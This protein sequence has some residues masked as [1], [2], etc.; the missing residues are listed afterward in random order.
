MNTNNT[1]F[2]VHYAYGNVTEGCL[3]EARYCY[4]TAFLLLDT[5]ISTLLLDTSISATSA[6][7]EHYQPVINLLD[8][9]LQ[10]VPDF[11]DAYCLREEVWRN[12]L[13]I[14]KDTENRNDVYNRYLLSE[15]W[16]DKK[17]QVLKRDGYRCVCCNTQAALQVHHKTYE[18]IG[19]EPLSDLASMCKSCHD[20]THERQRQQEKPAVDVPETDQVSDEDHFNKMATQ[21]KQQ[22]SVSNIKPPFDAQ[23]EPEDPSSNIEEDS[24]NRSRSEGDVVVT[25]VPPDD[26]PIY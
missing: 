5:P 1:Y 3:H 16:A 23:D 12:F 19:K 10:L 21:L 11:L 20:A 25:N 7:A 17:S 9:A 24:D 15:A 2:N 8:K 14:S 4:V 6:I 26:P 18:N 13:R 22:N